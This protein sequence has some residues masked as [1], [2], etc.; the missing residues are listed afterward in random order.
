MIYLIMMENA[1]FCL[2][3][4]LSFLNPNLFT[5]VRLLLEII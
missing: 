2:E 5:S 4:L 1:S 3:I